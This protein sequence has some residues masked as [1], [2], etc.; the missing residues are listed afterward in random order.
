LFSQNFI[1]EDKVWSIVSNGGMDN[2]WT[3]T[4]GLKFLG[5][6]IIQQKTYKKLYMAEDEQKQNWALSSLWFERND[7]VF[8]YSTLYEKNILVYDFTLTEKDSFT[9]RENDLYIIVDSIRTKEWGNKEREFYYF[10]PSLN[11]SFYNIQTV[12]IKGVG[13]L[14]FMTRSTEVDIWGPYSSL[15][16]FKEDGELVYQNPEYNSCSVFTAVSTI[17]KEP[18][19][20]EIYNPGGN[21]IIINPLTTNPGVIQIFDIKGNLIIEEE[22]EFEETQFCLQT[23]GAYI[24]RFISKTGEVQNGKVVVR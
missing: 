4:T 1:S 6:T 10:H 15:L 11:Y 22:I 9:I 3:V 17:K 7:S 2:P 5:D 24:Y 12:W 19:I 13:Q 14:G 8:R 21:R 16:C 18:E 20:V 23:T